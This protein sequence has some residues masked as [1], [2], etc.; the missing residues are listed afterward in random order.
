M[1]ST[2]FLCGPFRVFTGK[3]R[4]KDRRLAAQWAHQIFKLILADWGHMKFK[5]K[6]TPEDELLVQFILNG[7]NTTVSSDGATASLPPEQA[8][9]KYM[10]QLAS[11]GIAADFGLKK[12]GDRWGVVEV[13]II[14]AQPS[15]AGNSLKKGN[16]TSARGKGGTDDGDG[17]NG[18]GGGGRVESTADQEEVSKI[19]LTFSLLAPWAKNGLS[20]SKEYYAAQSLNKALAK[21]VAERQLDTLVTAADTRSDDSS[22]KTTDSGDVSIGIGFHI[23]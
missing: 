3:E 8:L 20:L 5:V 22:M 9:S 10:N 1:D 4:E 19:L 18:G 6:F 23:Y 2:K 17:D 7:S 15:K 12:R 21:R 16:N 13:G 11:H 14:S